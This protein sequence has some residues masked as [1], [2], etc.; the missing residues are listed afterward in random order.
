[1]HWALDK[2]VKEMKLVEY[3]PDISLVIH[4]DMED[5]DKEITLDIIVRNWLLLLGF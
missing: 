2:L 1:M 4:A 3:V 5:D